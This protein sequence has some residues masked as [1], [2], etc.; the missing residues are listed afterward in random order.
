[1]K[2]PKSFLLK[3]TLEDGRKLSELAKYYEVSRTEMIRHLIYKAYAH[4]RG[5][6]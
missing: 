5:D 3:Y 2:Y 4:L 6:A 1:M